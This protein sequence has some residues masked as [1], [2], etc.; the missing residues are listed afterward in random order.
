MKFN[1][2]MLFRVTLKVLVV[3]IPVLLLGSFFI[4]QNVTEQL[5]AEVGDEL[6]KE[7][8]LKAS[9]IR[10]ILENQKSKVELIRDYEAVKSMEADRIEPYF[11]QII[12]RNSSLWS[13]FLITDEEGTE[14]VHSE[15]EEYYGNNIAHKEYFKVPFETG[16]AVVAE[17]SFST[18]T[19][20]KI[21]GV[22]YPLKEGGEVKGVVAGFIKLD[23]LTRMLND[24]DKISKHSY[25]F[26][27][28]S[29]GRVA[30]HPDEEKVLTRNWLEP[31]EDEEAETEASK[32]EINSMS[33]G[34]KEIIANMTEGQDGF[35][36]AEVNGTRSVVAYQPLG[37]KDMSIA[38]VVPTDEAFAVLIKITNFLK[39]GIILISLILIGVFYYTLRSIVAPIKEAADF[40]QKIADGNL[41]IEDLDID[42]DDELGTLITSLNEMKD[43]LRNNIRE[44]VDN[45][46]SVVEDLTAYSEELSASAQEG[47]ASIETTNS[48]VEDISASIEQISASAQEVSNFAEQ[49]RSKTEAGSENIKETLESINQ[50]NY[51]TGDAFNE[52]NQLDETAQEIEGIVELIT[53]ISEQT[54]LLALNAAIEAARAGEAGQGFAVV[55]EEIRE[56]AEET[57]DA[58]DKVRNLINQTQNRAENGLSAIKEV[59][60]EAAEGKVVAEKTKEVFKE[61][62]EASEETARQIEQTAGA[63]QNLAEQSQEVRSSTQ[64][65]K[66]M[67]DDIAH[68]SQEL[69]EMS[70]NLQEIIGKFDV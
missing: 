48:L 63:T 67:S 56:L 53:N 44:L 35:K 34:F 2:S 42:Y 57:N 3:V 1:K 11:K 29:N 26:I 45:A 49:S 46:A 8:Q 59:S 62:K 61:I 20:R 6:C 60:K 13:H 7:L 28:N 21:M 52:I 33:T 18:S 70:Q 50:I 15:G 12:E 55:A 66:Q 69:T 23:Y 4:Y 64:D 47:N 24:E 58:T 38:T 65:I 5:K 37:I 40:S 16:E 27:L 68:S 54:N 36:V 17:P 39:I 31:E 51:S 25:S 30:T 14:I 10:N 41:D 19:G 32:E 43:N 9:N 22:G